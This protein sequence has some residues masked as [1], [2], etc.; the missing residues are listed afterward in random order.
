MDRWLNLK[1]K[2]TN[3]VDED[4]SCSKDNKASSSNFKKRRQYSKEY[5]SIGFTYIGSED[6]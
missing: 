3:D 6:N 2:N 5:L 4:A 1:R